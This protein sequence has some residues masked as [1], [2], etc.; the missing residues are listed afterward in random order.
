[1]KNHC[2]PQNIPKNIPKYFSTL[3][4]EIFYCQIQDVEVEARI[5]TT[6]YLGE[7]QHQVCTVYEG[8]SS[9]TEEMIL[10]EYEIFLETRADFYDNLEIFSEGDFNE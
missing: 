2:Q 1:M 3:K 4:G 7:V 6:D 8:D 10:K 9:I 5:L